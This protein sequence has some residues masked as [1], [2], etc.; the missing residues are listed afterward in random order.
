MKKS[1][2]QFS[3]LVAFFILATSEVKNVCVYEINMCIKVIK[4]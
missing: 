3:L 1:W 4:C 2:K